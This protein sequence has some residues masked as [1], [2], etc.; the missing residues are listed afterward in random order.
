MLELQRQKNEHPHPCESC[1]GGEEK[2]LYYRTLG[3]S[4][5][6]A[7]QQ[8][9]DKV[10]A[11]KRSQTESDAQFCDHLTH[12]HLTIDVMKTIV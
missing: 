6:D 10:Y 4:C 1:D 3:D 7:L 5:S 9:G 8:H 12:A 2:D 11:S